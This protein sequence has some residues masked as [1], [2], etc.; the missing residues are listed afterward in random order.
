MARLSSI[1]RGGILFF[2]AGAA[3]TATASLLYRMRAVRRLRR[4]A[5][6]HAPVERLDGR[7]EIP[8]LRSLPSMLTPLEEARSALSREP[9]SSRL[10]LIGPGGIGKSYTARAFAAHAGFPALYVRTSS[11]LAATPELTRS[12][13]RDLA[14]RVQRLAPA[15]LVLDGL[16]ILYPNQPELEREAQRSLTEELLAF[17]ENP[18][19]RILIIGTAR[20]GTALPENACFDLIIP[21]QVAQA[22]QG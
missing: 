1:S 10:L 20:D 19:L 3:A 5:L 7:G 2:L 11:L 6:T 13:V 4:Q 17:L 18:P 12:R 9:R 8:V 21:M 15:V 22:A 14:E 16:E